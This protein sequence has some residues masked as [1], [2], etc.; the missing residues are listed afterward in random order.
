[1]AQSHNE[2]EITCVPFSITSGVQRFLIFK[3]LTGASLRSNKTSV[4]E[5]IIIVLV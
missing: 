4:D 5:M 2:K 3:A 1:M